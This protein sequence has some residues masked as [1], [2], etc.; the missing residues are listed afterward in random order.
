MGEEIVI[1]RA[2][3]PVARLVPANPRPQRQLGV[4]VGVFEVPE[5]FD[6]PLPE[7]VLEDFEG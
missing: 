4:D 6:A 3:Q 5:D 2:G 7:A 1:S